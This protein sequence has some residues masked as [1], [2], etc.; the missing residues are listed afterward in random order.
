M[1][2]STIMRPAVVVSTVVLFAALSMRFAP[3]A[4]AA[5]LLV[6]EAKSFALIGK[7]GAIASGAAEDTLKACMARIPDVASAGQ[8]M[9]SEQ[10]CVGE[11]E[12]RKAIRSAPKF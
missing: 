1:R 7:L 12:T 11:E 9:L 3:P 4:Y 10:S 6:E 8:R 5:Y 2:I